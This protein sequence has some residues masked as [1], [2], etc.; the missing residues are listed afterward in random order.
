MLALAAVRA[1]YAHVSEPDWRTGR[2]AV[3]TGLLAKDPLYGTGTAQERWQASARAN[4]AAEL[5][6]LRLPE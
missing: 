5:R 1:E 2:V 4:L 3:L 6:S